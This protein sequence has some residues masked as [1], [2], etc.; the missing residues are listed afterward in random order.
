GRDI[1][2]MEI[3]EPDFPTP[4]AVIAAGIRALQGGNIK[5]TTAAGLPELRERISA[6]YR[7]VYHVE[8]PL[9]RIVVTPGG[10]GALLVA[11]AMLVNRGARILMADPCYPCNRNMIHLFDGQADLIP[12]AA[13]RKYQLDLRSVESHWN[14][15]CRGVLIA[16]PSNPAGTLI[17]PEDLKEIIEFVDKREGFVISDEIYHGL[18][19]DAPAATALQYSENVFVVNSFSKYFG[20]TGWRIGWLVVP[21]K[22]VDGV[23]KLVQNLFISAPAHSQF[24]ALAAFEPDNIRELERRKE[25]FRARRDYVYERLTA[26]GF[27][28]PVKPG[29]AFYLYAGCE[30]FS[31]DSFEF[32]DDLLERF[33]IAITPGKDF[34]NYRPESHVR[35]AYTTSMERLTAGLDRLA[36]AL[37]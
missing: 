29:G 25:A 19:Y 11:F 31:A 22:A 17:D 35:F 21:E 2:H 37:R 24:A 33:G 15:D 28:I 20:M 34:G 13:D 10:S 12:V 9:E 36:D 16:S 4:P 32:A 7:R 6:Y 8:V 14:D 3:G 5:Y 23:E 1:V 30:R 18:H 27:D 26:I